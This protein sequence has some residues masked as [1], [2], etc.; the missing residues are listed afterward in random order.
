MD[1]KIFKP[2]THLASK[3]YQYAYMCM[4]LCP[5]QGYKLLSCDI[6]PVLQVEQV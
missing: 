6:E 1:F 5:P 2:D 4:C 3:D